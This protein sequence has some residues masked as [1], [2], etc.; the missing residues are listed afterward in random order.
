LLSSAETRVASIRGLCDAHTPWTDNLINRWQPVDGYHW[1]ACNGKGTPY[2]SGGGIW[3]VQTPYGRGFK[4]VVTPEMTVPS[5]GK[6]ALVVDFDHLV[7]GVGHTEVWSGMFM[8]PRAGNPK[9]FPRN[10]PDFAV[11]FEFHTEGPV[12][13]MG[14]GID[15]TE[16][17]Y[18]NNIYFSSNAVSPHR[19]VLDRHQVVY[20]HWYSWRIRVKWSYGTDGVSE[21]WLDGRRLASWKGP[22]L[23][24]GEHPYLQ[25]GFYSESE[26]R[27]EVWHAGV[28]R[29]MIAANDS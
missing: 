14:I 9:G 29:R 13:P 10:Y 1:S 26:L 16:A 8:L 2:A 3:E 22:T 4:M 20:D 15:T 17:P 25:F 19:K 24:Q 12:N 27:N 5:G 6:Q 23:S 28:R 7:R 18:R 21:C 11:L